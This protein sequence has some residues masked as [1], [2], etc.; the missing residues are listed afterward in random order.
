[1]TRNNPHHDLVSEIEKNLSPLQNQLQ[2]YDEIVEAARDK[3]F[4]LLGEAS[5]G[6]AEFYRARIEITQ[7]LI[8]ECGFDAVVVEADWPDAYR[9]NKYVCQTSND[10]TADEALADFERFPTWMWRNTEVKDFIT[11][12]EK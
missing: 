6:T 9:V 7:R 2:D 3:N 11:W 1:M 8:F 5:H 4:V 12:L 10:Q